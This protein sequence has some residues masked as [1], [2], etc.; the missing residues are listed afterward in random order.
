[1]SMD[2]ASYPHRDMCLYTLELSQHRT[3]GK[4]EMCEEILHSI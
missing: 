3:R 4:E 1:M 2:E